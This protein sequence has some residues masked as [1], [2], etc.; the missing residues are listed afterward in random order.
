MHTDSKKHI[1]PTAA[2][3]SLI[4]AKDAAMIEGKKVRHRLF[5]DD[6][7]IYYKNGCW[8]TEDGYQIPDSYWLNAQK[9]GWDDSWSVVS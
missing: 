9:A 3:L 2:G 7:Y 8:F 5:T 4:Q 1:T 6:E